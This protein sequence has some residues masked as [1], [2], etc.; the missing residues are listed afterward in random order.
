MQVESWCVIEPRLSKIILWQCAI[1]LPDLETNA[2]ISLPCQGIDPKKVIIIDS[3]TS[4]LGLISPWS[5]SSSSSKDQSNL[6]NVEKTVLAAIT[7]AKSSE[8]NTS[9]NAAADEGDDDGT[10]GP[11][12]VLVLDGLDFLL[13]ATACSVV[14]LIDMLVELRE[15]SRFELCR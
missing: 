5:S 3:L 4:G 7:K 9:E 6:V 8:T 15:V 2:Y 13:A 14:S 12:I 10:S 1:L 11:R